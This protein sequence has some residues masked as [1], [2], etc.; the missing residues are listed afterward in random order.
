MLAQRLGP[1][2]AAR[3]VGQQ[4]QVVRIFQLELIQRGQEL[5]ILRDI[6]ATYRIDRL[7]TSMERPLATK[8]RS[9][10]GEGIHPLVMA[11]RQA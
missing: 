7:S 6:L 4:R 2:I 11:C 1:S 9:F 5:K 3:R 8:G 10:A